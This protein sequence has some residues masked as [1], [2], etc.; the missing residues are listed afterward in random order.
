M[1]VEWGIEYDVPLYAFMRFKS[2]IFLMSANCFLI[3][4]NPHSTGVAGEIIGLV[5]KLLLSRG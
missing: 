4:I 5:E 3:R 1:E 2:N